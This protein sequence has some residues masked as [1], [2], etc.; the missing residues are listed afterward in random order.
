MNI[1]LTIKGLLSS[2]LLKIFP[3]LGY[4]GVV[5]VQITVYNR[6]RLKYPKASE[7]DLLNSLIMSRIESFP[8]MT[9][10][11]IERAHYRPLLENP[12]KTLYDVIWA[13]I[14]YENI[15]S[16]EDDIQAKFA[17][18]ELPQSFVTAEMD[19][20]KEIWKTY[21]KETIEKKR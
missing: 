12:D 16:R 17:R 9:S 14:E 8:A 11:V 10:S 5:N 1:L 19:S 15:L 20:Q 2:L 3:S 13:I 18:M 4:R 21:I 7:N 6:L